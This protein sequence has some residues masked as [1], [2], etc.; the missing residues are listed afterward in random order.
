MDY[1]IKINTLDNIILSCDMLRLKFKFNE[2]SSKE[3]FSY[4]KELEYYNHIN[5][6]Y[7][8]SRGLFKYR[9]L[10][11]IVI[12]VNKSSFALGVGFNGVKSS[13]KKSCFIEFNPNKCLFENSILLDIIQYIKYYSFD[14][15]LVRYDLAIDIPIKRSCVTLMKDLRNY[16]KNYYLDLNSNSLENLTEYLGT[17]N[18][19]GFVKLYNKKLEQKLDYDLTRLEITLEDYDY[20]NFQKQLPVLYFNKNMNLF[21]YNELNDTDKVLIGLMSDNLNKNIYFKMLGRVKQEKL[22]KY[23]FD[24]TKVEINISDYLELVKRVKQIYA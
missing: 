14:L 9:N 21:E 12:P 18:S 10:F 11:N 7:H 24:T 19:N 20:E 16:R 2:Y 3:F 22:K 13:D 4:I 6:E 23:I 8:E 15:E 1:F 5:L 17:R